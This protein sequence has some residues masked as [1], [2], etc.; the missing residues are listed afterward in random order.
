[1]EIEELGFNGWHQDRVDSLKLVDKQIARVIT[2]NKNSYIVSNGKSE[3][4]AEITGKLMYSADS[5][6]DYPAV[7]DWVYAQFLD[8]DTFA[9]IHEILPRESLLKRKVAGKKIEFQIIAANIDSAL[10]IQSLDTDFNLNRLERYLVMVSEGN[11]E[12]VILLSKSDLLEPKRIGEKK[13]EIREAMPDIKTIDF[14]NLDEAN[15]DKVEELLV[16][17][18][19][20]CLLGSSGV[21]KTTL[22]NRLVNQEM[23]ETRPVRE[24]DGKGKHVTTRRQLIILKNGAMIVD[25]PGMRELGSIDI[26]SGLSETFSE[27][28]ELANHCRFNDCTHTQEDGCAVLAALDEG[29][30]PKKRYQNYLKLRKEA[31]FHDMSYLEKRRKDK[32][33]GK[34]VKSAMKHKKRKK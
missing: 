9:I 6:L 23:F 16:P 30:L 13:T 11:I 31:E 3:V 24:K 33:F 22:L 8:D 1:M 29:T 14:S 28:A 17:R 19:V 10:I 5:P 27:I 15:L 34:M 12:P 21:G 4:F 7:G 32:Q 20:F 18:K 25:T 26:E 2:V